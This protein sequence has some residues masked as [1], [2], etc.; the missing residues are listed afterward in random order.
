MLAA[1]YI[2]VSGLGQRDG[3]GPERQ[4]ERNQRCAKA[5]GLEIVVTGFDLGVTGD[6]AADKREG[7]SSLLRHLLD[8]G[9]TVLLVEDAR[10]LARNLI[11]QELAIEEAQ[12]LGITVISSDGDVVLTDSSDTTRVLIRQVLGAV[13]QFDK[14]NTVKKLRG[15]RDRIRSRLGKCEGPKH[16]GHFPGEQETLSRI[17]SLSASHSLRR[18][19]EVLNAEQRP[20]RT[21][22]PWVFSTIAKIL[23]GHKCQETVTANE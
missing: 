18:I 23:R 8:S 14:N 11:V 3:D 7:Y 17:L 15:A 22:K 6:L 16:F 19:A 2:R 20:T 4:D 5:R 13:G 21:G 12:R 9:V 10:R 1:Q